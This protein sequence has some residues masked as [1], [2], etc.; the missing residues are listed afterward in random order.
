MLL[1]FRGNFGPFVNNANLGAIACNNANLGA[2]AAHTSH[3]T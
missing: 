2:I 3:G 1:Q